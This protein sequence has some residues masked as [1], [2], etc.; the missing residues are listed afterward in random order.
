[1]DI[2][3]NTDEVTSQRVYSE[4]FSVAHGKIKDFTI[5]AEFYKQSRYVVEH[6]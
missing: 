6:T 3:N 2:D 4:Q 5:S 1:M